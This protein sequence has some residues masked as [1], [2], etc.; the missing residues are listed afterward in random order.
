MRK[1]CLLFL[2]LLAKPGFSQ[3]V[4]QLDYIINNSGDSS[5][6]EISDAGWSINPETITFKQGNSKKT[7][8]V[9]DLSGFAVHGV[10]VYT[11]RTVKYQLNP[12]N[13]K[14]AGT[15]YSN[16]EE[17]KS[18]WLRVV[19]N[20]NFNLYELSTNKRQYFFIE[21]QSEEIKELIF[22]V[23]FSDGQLIKD[24]IFKNQLLSVPG[25]SDNKKLIRAIDNASYNEKDLAGVFALL[26]N[27]NSSFYSAER[28]KNEWDVNVEA[29]INFLTASGQYEVYNNV[30]TLNL[31]TV[32]L[33]STIGFRAGTGVSFAVKKD[34]SVSIRAGLEFGSL[35]IKANG[36][37]NSVSG[38]FDRENYSGTLF[39]V[40]PGLALNIRL[41]KDSER[42]F[43]ISPSIGYYVPVNKNAVK[44]KLETD[45]SI[46]VSKKGIPSIGGAYETGLSVFLKSGQSK[47]GI[48]G[49][50][51]SNLI[52]SGNAKWSG[53][54]I[55]VAYSYIFTKQSK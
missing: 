5:F 9:N 19:V 15:S 8:S 25:A 50:M 55:G 37:S 48:H 26:N 1:I 6:G 41:N 47:I 33:N 27:G 20:G 18:V 2:V 10:A 3:S 54:G 40:K 36:G 16:N 31:H 46:L 45:P 7:Y 11:R 44:A 28:T 29:G 23:R 53:F 39:F 38:S 35:G 22:K 13:Y 4:T 24:E 42:S 49:Y 14:D 12:S 32:K 17:T 34:N 43:F 30:G 52:G 51:F 21:K